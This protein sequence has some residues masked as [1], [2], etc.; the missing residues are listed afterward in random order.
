[1][2]LQDKVAIVTGSARGLGRAI[3]TRLAKEGAKVVVTDMDQASC[4]Q[5]AEEIVAGGGVAMA[6]ACNVTDR[7]A[8]QA[9]AT[10]TV[11]RYGK[12]DILVNNAGI[13]KDA[14]LKKMTDD[15][16]DAVINV[17]LKAVFICTQEI[18]RYMV[19]QKSGRVI[20]MSSLAGVEGNFGQT[21]YS[22]SKAGIIGMTKT[23]AKELGK[24]R[25]TAN[26]IAPGFMDTEMTRTIPQNIVDQMLAKI[27]VGRAGR[28]E[29]VAAAV[30]Y[31]ASDEA[32]F[33]NGV[34]LNVNGG[35]YVM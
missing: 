34:T 35:M 30:V 31:L 9:L 6:V 15:Q 10:A 12:I 24:S 8:V 14:S 11:A 29:E 5:V 2:R 21:N 13:T 17:N 3:V 32:G 20:S 28:P 16:W 33:V 26:A 23:W 7:A 19:E 18:T 27:P 4:D 22:A 1:M 25:V